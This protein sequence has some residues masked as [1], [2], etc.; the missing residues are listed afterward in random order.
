[1]IAMYTDSIGHPSGK[2]LITQLIWYAKGISRCIP[3][4]K[5]K[6]KPIKLLEDTIEG[7]SL[8]I[9]Y[10]HYFFFKKKNNSP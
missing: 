2:Q 9:C 3:H 1:M 8:G 5:I 7:I 10:R 6:Y 4:R